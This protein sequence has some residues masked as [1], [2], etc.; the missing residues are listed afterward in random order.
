MS[1]PLGV[2]DSPSTI[3]DGGCGDMVVDRD[4]V[5][6]RGPS[7]PIIV[8]VTDTDSLLRGG[9]TDAGESPSSWCCCTSIDADGSP[10]DGGWC[11]LCD[12]TASSGHVEKPKGR[13]GDWGS[14][15]LLDDGV[16]IAGGVWGNRY[17]CGSR[18]NDRVERGGM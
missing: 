17:V 16:G 1:I 7:S 6:D 15:G 14:G 9:P 2:G 5:A 11:R 3:T 12:W 13:D 8:S 4:V 10:C 18:D